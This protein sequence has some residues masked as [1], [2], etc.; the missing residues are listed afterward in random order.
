MEDF[1]AIWLQYNLNL[2]K[3]KDNNY[4]KMLEEQYVIKIL[5]LHL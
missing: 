3:I 2:K 5:H 4:M 1:Y